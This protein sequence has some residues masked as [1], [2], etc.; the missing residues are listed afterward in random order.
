MKSFSI[1]KWDSIKNEL[2]S[3]M[4]EQEQIYG[5]LIGFID[6]TSL[7]ATDHE[8]KIKNLVQKALRT[9]N[10]GDNKRAV[11][12]V[13]VYPVFV[14]QVAEALKGTGIQVAAVAGAFPSGQSPLYLRLEEVKYAL[15]EGATEIDMVISRGK[16]LVGDRDFIFKEVYE[17]KKVCGDAHL[18][19]ILETGELK[20]S[21]LIYEASM[22]SMKAGADFIKTS[23]GKIQPAAT[24]E[25]SWVMLEA[26]KDFYQKTGKKVGFKAAG[27]ITEAATAYQ[28]Y[29]LVK[30]ILGKDWLTPSLFRIGASRLLDQLLQKIHE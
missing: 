27:G 13:C 10:L 12:A 30:K 15:N 16:M 1:E 2:Y 29:A 8:E 25:A 9:I 4:I 22:I 28:Y 6:L 23:T 7:E 19:V 5:E 20:D 14:R 3:E 26:I 21:E 18:K 24:L 17:H 11:A